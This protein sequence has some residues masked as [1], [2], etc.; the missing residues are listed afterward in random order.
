MNVEKINKKPKKSYMVQEAKGKVKEKKKR[1]S[2]RLEVNATKT[3][4]VRVHNSEVAYTGETSKH[5]RRY[6]HK[7]I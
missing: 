7:L 2:E 5:N 6:A 1:R 3:H 4:M